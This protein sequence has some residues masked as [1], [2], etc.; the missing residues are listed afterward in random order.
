[1]PTK[2]QVQPEPYTEAELAEIGNGI[3]NLFHMRLDREFTIARGAGRRW[4]TAWGNKTDL[5]L[6]RTFLS[7]AEGLLQREP[8]AL[9]ELRKLTTK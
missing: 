3:A 5:G 2:I 7:L 1:M 9:E 8:K 4:R 6:A